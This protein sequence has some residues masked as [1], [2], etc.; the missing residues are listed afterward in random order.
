VTIEKTD[1]SETVDELTTQKSAD[2]LAAELAKARARIEE[3]ENSPTTVLPGLVTDATKKTAE[4][5]FEELL[6]KASP[7]ERLRY[8]LAAHTGGR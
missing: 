3:L 7:S 8:S 4:S 2:E 1:E 6:K 5:D